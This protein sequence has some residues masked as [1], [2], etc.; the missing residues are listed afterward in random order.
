[1]GTRASVCAD[2]PADIG[3]SVGVRRNLALLSIALH[4][5]LMSLTTNTHVLLPYQRRVVFLLK[6]TMVGESVRLLVD[7][8][9]D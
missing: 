4:A 8:P 1:M 5:R 9:T 3:F 7:G 6:H 2:S